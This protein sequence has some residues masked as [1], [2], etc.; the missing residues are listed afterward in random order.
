MRIQAIAAVGANG[1]LGHKGIIP[2]QGQLPRDMKFFME[3]TKGSTLIM[4][5]KT[6]DSLRLPLKGRESIIITTKVNEMRERYTDHSAVAAS[7]DAAMHY[8]QNIICATN[9]FI[10]GGAEIYKLAAN[11]IETM[12]LTTVHG[13]FRA[14]TFFHFDKDQFNLAWSQH[15]APDDKNGF[16]CT[17]ETYHRKG[18]QVVC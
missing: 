2:W 14:D 11:L 6:A 8:A 15:F 18:S 5:R 12:Y 13:D 10:I 3:T 4:G 1:E 17:F 16:G 9:V 7:L